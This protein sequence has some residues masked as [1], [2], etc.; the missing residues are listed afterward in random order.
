MRYLLLSWGYRIE[1]SKFMGMCTMR[2]K[3]FVSTSLFLVSVMSSVNFALAAGDPFENALD[4]LANSRGDSKAPVHGVGTLDDMANGIGKNNA[5]SGKGIDAAIQDVL[6]DQAEKKA[7]AERQKRI[8]IEQEVKQ[9]DADMESHCACIFHSCDSG[10]RLVPAR[11]SYEER[12]RENERMDEA[13]RLANDARIREI[14]ICNAWK[15]AGPKAN[16]ESFKA[17]LRQQDAALAAAQNSSAEAA[18]QRDAVI[19]AETK[20]RNAQQ[21]NAVKA[22]LKAD[23]DAENARIAA[24]KA[25]DAARAAEQE[26]KLRQGCLQPGSEGDCACVKYHP[27]IKYNAC[28]K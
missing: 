5:S 21:E 13:D 4:S 18:R 19:D 22:K 25:K 12:I 1:A 15:A 28:S 7:Q 8:Q 17:Q 24:K 16:S 11:L 2:F 9:Q 26:E 23:Q 14:P 27:E 10:L 6:A 20:R 3:V